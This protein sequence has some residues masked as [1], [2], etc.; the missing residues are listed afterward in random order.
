MIIDALMIALTRLSDV[1]AAVVGS[2]RHPSV[3][4]G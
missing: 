1:L 3:N 2:I 4:G